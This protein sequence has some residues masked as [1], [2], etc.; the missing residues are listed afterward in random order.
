MSGFTKNPTFIFFNAK[1]KITLHK[2]IHGSEF[3]P[4]NEEGNILWKKPM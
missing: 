4:D 3:N 1:N 2:V